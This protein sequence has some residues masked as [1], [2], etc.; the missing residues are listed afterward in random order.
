M[1]RGKK[2]QSGIF[3]YAERKKKSLDSILFL[4]SE[5]NLNR[6]GVNV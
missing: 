6:K 1:K 5:K 2:K 4:P 3:I